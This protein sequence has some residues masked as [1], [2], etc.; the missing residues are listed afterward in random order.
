LVADLT[1]ILDSC[2]DTEVDPDWA[3]RWLEHI[4]AFLGGLPADQR[5]RVASELTVLANA[6][7]SPTARLW[8][9]DFPESLGLVDRMD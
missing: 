1:W 5:E 7:T 2:D 6:E 8:L 4:A 9:E 3:A